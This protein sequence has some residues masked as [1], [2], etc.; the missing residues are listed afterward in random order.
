MPDKVDKKDIEKKRDVEVDA[1]PGDQPK[2]TVTLKEGGTGVGVDVGTMNLVSARHK[3]EKLVT[4][5]MRDAFFTLEKT[6]QSEK[7]V[8]LQKAEYIEQDDIYL[9]LGQSAFDFANIAP[10]S[11]IQRPLSKGTISPKEKQ[12]AEVLAAMLKIL[13][14]K[15]RT[16]GEKLIYSVPAEAVDL[17]N[18][19]I[20]HRKLFKEIFESLGYSA[21]HMNEAMGIIF[22]QCEDEDFSGVALSFGAGN[23]NCVLSFQA[24][25]GLSFASARAGDWIDE[26]VAYSLGSSASRVA[27]AKETEFDL[28]DYKK[29]PKK[30]LK[31]RQALA[32]YFED[33]IDYILD[34][35]TKQF[36]MKASGFQLPKPIPIVVSG[37]CSKAKGFLEWFTEK[38]E[39]KYRDK[40]PLEISEIR[41]AKDPLTAVAEGML[42]AALL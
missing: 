5:T 21:E 4:K 20:F 23:T 19:I 35:F 6:A 13:C 28:R 41:Q 42:T 2:A 14:G 9:I 33:L 16:E 24:K 40:F 15:P 37:G 22:S 36:I 3:G 12:A 38:F 18:D 7:T 39:T 34:T 29:G 17:D 31:M 25:E 27:M 26:R 32:F 11:F 10:D 1:Q 30:D 8:R